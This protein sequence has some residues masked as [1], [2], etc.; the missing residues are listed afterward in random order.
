VSNWLQ[1]ESGL[2]T[3][4]V[5]GV[6]LANQKTI[7]VHHVIE[8]KENLRV[9]LISCLF[10]VLGSRLAPSDLLNLGWPGIVFVAALLVVIR[11]A[12]VFLSTLGT[13][14]RVNER[15]FL[16]FLAPRGIVAAAVSS[17]FAL[18]LASSVSQETQSS[19]LVNQAEQLVPITFLVIVATVLV[20]GLL[21]G[22]LARKLGLA[23]PT[24]QGI[25]F[26]GAHHWVRQMAT[27]LYE[28]DFAVL[29]VDTNYSHVAKA[30]MEDLPA[31]CA[32]ILSEHVREEMDL[33]GIGRLLAMTP[34]D[35]VN[36]LAIREFTAEFGR[37][38]VYQLSPWDT[39]AGRR[40]SVTEHMQGRPL[41]DA[42]AHWDMLELF[43]AR[44]GTIKKT[45]LSNEFDFQA[46]QELYGE[47]AILLF[48]I[49]ENRKLII[50]TADHSA[51]PK[52]GQT[53]VAAV[54]PIETTDQT[55]KV[56][57]RSQ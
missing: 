2:V 11:P 34:S 42:A 3:V 32:S 5:L 14:L 47:S 28:E 10:I 41:F 17:V 53:V 50:C 21:A 16:A 22:P 49:D 33:S 1:H 44:G 40:Q 7:P 55:D 54:E 8:F 43:F 19:D 52:P 45:K 29:L 38:K 25:L 23:D 57:A 13:T 56:E 26:T 24:P 18:K 20:Y 31:E 51:E 30:R 48:V 46:F 36:A 15:I 9:L 39:G 4:T 35:E 6:F 27:V 12:S 37:A